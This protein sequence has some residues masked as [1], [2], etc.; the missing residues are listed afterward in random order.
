M[1]GARHRWPLFE[2]SA[3]VLS[4][5]PAMAV[6]LWMGKVRYLHRQQDLN[7]SFPLDTKG[8]PYTRQRCFIDTRQARDRQDNVTTMKRCLQ[9][10][11]P[12]TSLPCS[13]CMRGPLVSIS[14]TPVF[15]QDICD[16]ATVRSR[17]VGAKE[18]PDNLIGL[19]TSEHGVF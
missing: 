3:S 8:P 9:P 10:R 2:S 14:A 12:V 15:S 19:A 11:A 4:L 18:A 16:V 7:S 17:R 5:H 13:T 1:P 6:F